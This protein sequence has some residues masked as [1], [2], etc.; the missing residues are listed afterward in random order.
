MT[1]ACD[2]RGAPDHDQNEV[3]V[4]CLG[5][6][7]TDHTG[8]ERLVAVSGGTM[9]DSPMLRLDV[10]RTAG[11]VTIRVSGELDLATSPILADRLAAEIAA[12][13]GDVTVALGGVGFLD[14]TALR[15]LVTAHRDLAAADRRLQLTEPRASTLRVLEIAGLLAMFGFGDQPA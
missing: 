6:E 1:G 15:V 7:P 9:S 13:T 8:R 2:H 11:G 10:E 12:G 3:G 4:R 14:S 5:V